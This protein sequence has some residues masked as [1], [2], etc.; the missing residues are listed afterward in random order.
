M[1]SKTLLALLLVVDGSAQVGNVPDKNPRY[2]PPGVFADGGQ[3]ADFRARWYGE[4]LR[5]MTEPSLS[6]VVSA[7]KPPTFRFT[8]L[9]SFHDPIAAR[10]TV[11]GN[12]TGTLTVKMADG[13]GGRRPSKPMLGFV[14]E[15]SADEIRRVLRLIEEMDFWKMP[16]EPGGPPY[17]DGASWILEACVGGRY[18]V[19]DRQSPP[20]GPLRE[21][22]LYLVLALAKLD[23]PADAI[24]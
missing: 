15:M 9:R 7:G 2:F 16:A 19:I 10:V 20:N 12:G 23:I 14:K 22:G 1:R 17:P 5:A 11:R 8:W 18:H 4:T 3:D 24:Y 21:L 13:Q 6:E